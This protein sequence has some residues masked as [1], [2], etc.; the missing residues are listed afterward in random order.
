M[1]PANKY[2]AKRTVCGH[3]HTHDSKME[4]AR[5]DALHALQATGNIAGLEQQPE[6]PVSINGKKVCTYKADFAYFTAS[7]RIVEDVKGMLTPVYRLKKKLVEAA[8]PG[9]VI[10]EYPP[11]IRKARKPR[12]AA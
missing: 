7:T 9:T 12:K 2:S 8:H 1:K 3:G 6:F 11:R 10:T 4:A 5:C